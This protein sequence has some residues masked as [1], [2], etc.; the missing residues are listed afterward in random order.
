VSDTYTKLFS[1]IT[2]STIWQEPDGTRLTWITMLAMAKKDGCV[3]GSV[4]GLAHQA[5][6]S[7]E[8]VRTALACF[9]APDPDSRTK[10]F[11]G[12][13]IEEIDGGWRLL[14]HEKFRQ[15]RSAEERREY[16]REYMRAKRGKE[17]LLAEPLAT[18]TDV[19][20]PAPAPTLYT[21][22][23]PKSETRARGSRILESWQPSEDLKRWAQKARPDVDA[24]L[25]AE[26]FRNFWM[27]AAGRNAVKMN[28][29]AAWRNWIVKSK[30]TSA[31]NGHSKTF[32]KLSR[33]QRLKDEYGSADCDALPAT[34]VP[35]LG[36]DSGG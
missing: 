24:A 14:N 23:E 13:R 16:M 21:K 6:V 28:W 12:R 15:I 4:P 7:V 35:R 18:S 20:P 8:A 33:L 34:G 10:D 11:D 36:G 26:T 25:E 19:A 5:K 30:P 3:Y 29:D 9:L 27:A 1:S 17:K 2:A 31:V 32:T 22:K